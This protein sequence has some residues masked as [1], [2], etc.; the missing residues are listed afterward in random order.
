MAHF[1]KLVYLLSNILALINA[2]KNCDCEFVFES[3]CKI[4]K[5]YTEN[6]EFKNTDKLKILDGQNASNNFSLIKNKM[7]SNLSMLA[8]LLLMDCRIS[9]IESN[10][11][12]ELENLQNLNLNLNNLREF[13]PFTFRRLI[14]LKILALKSNFIEKLDKNTFIFNTNLQHLYLDRNRIKIIEVRTFQSLIN[15]KE[16]SLSNNLISAIEP[17]TFEKLT[18]DVELTGNICINKALTKDNRKIGYC[19]EEFP[20]F[21]KEQPIIMESLLEMLIYIFYVFVLLMFIFY[22]MSLMLDFFLKNIIF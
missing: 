8:S 16:L 2:S 17:K 22:V 14:N 10:A 19:A 11:F 18:A 20:L 13:H 12:I 4:S 3:I 6:L 1:V 9:E 5:C 7:F 21:T 15:L